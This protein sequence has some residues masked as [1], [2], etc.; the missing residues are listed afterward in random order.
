MDIPDIYNLDDFNMQP[1]NVLHI[2]INEVGDIIFYHNDIIIETQKRDQT[3]KIFNIKKYSGNSKYFYM[4]NDKDDNIIFTDD[5]PY[6][7]SLNVNHVYRTEYYDDIL[8]VNYK[9][10]LDTYFYFY[11]N[12]IISKNI[13][14]GYLIRSV[15]RKNT[16]LYTNMPT[17]PY[18]H[19][20]YIYILTNSD[21][22]YYSSAYFKNQ[23]FIRMMSMYSLDINGEIYFYMYK[24]NND[25]I[26]YLHKMIYNDAPLIFCI[27][28]GDNIIHNY[29]NYM[30]NYNKLASNRKLRSISI[31]VPY[32]DKFNYFNSF[33][34]RED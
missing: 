1:S 28:Q 34:F 27:K 23:K 4:V 5:K 25:I 33:E 19:I 15:M 14:M 7:P 29:G 12:N 3:S 31:E 21:G 18:P 24:I 9:F 8:I 32:Y 6:S 13:R 11:E 22:R 20:K 30:E 26:L 2:H 10:D 16:N 17:D